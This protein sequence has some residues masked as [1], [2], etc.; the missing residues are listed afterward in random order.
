MGPPDKM[1]KIGA[2]LPQIGGRQGQS[3]QGPSEE[4][5]RLR[6]S[7]AAS[8]AKDIEEEIL[9]GERPKVDVV[10][11]PYRNLETLFDLLD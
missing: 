7:I 9:T 5:R 1:F 4:W 3:A 6:S 2:A 10:G 8:L 11:A